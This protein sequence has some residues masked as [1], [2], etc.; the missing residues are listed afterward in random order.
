MN[1]LRSGGREKRLTATRLLG[2]RPR[3]YAPRGTRSR[4]AMT[5]PTRRRRCGWATKACAVPGF[6]R[7]CG[8]WTW[9]PAAVPSASRRRA[10]ARRC[11]RRTSLRSCSSVARSSVRAGRARHRDPRHGRPRARAGRRQ[12]RHGRIAVRRHAVSRHAE[13][14]QRDGARRQARR[15]RAD[16]RVRRSAQD[17]VLRASSCAPFSRSGPASRPPDGSSSASVPAAGS[18]E[19]APGAR[20]RPG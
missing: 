4:R 12:L 5:G 6:V 1:T 17:R 9:R 10:S 13:G 20:R 8:S 14:H 18:G 7:A 15:P 2:A 16:E 3:R 19:A 11:W